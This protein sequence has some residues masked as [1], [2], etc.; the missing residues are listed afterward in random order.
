MDGKYMRPC[1]NF[2]SNPCMVSSQLVNA[3][4]NSRS[5]PHIQLHQ[6]TLC[7]ECV[8]A[9]R[10]SSSWSIPRR[11]H[12]GVTAYTGC[13]F[14]VDCRFRRFRVRR[15]VNRSQLD[16]LP[17]LLHICAEPTCRCIHSRTNSFEHTECT[18]VGF[19][20]NC[21]IE[22][23]T[24]RIKRQKEHNQPE[25]RL[26]EY[27]ATYSRIMLSGNLKFSQQYIQEFMMTMLN[28]T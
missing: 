21:I 6:C 15:P 18:I 13:L 16:D 19:F 20:R 2:A 28:V 24:E 17:E 11:R 7:G 4:T 12:N 1:T 26:M 14:L 25:L 5:L 27:W 23:L 10:S 8:R 22:M 9:R 3:F